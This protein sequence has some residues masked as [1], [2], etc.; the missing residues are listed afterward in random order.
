[1]RILHAPTGRVAEKRDG[2]FM[3]FPVNSNLTKDAERFETV[4]EAALFLLK[5]PDWN[6][7]VK[8]NGTSN[9]GQVKKGIVIEGSFDMDDLRKRRV[10][11]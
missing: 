5:N 11:Y 4:E 2:K 1:M 10:V 6:I 3:C 7:W 9:D 8:G